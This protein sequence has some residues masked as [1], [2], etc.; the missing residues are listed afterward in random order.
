[1]LLG[2]SRIRGLISLASVVAVENRVTISIPARPIQRISQTGRFIQA[3]LVECG[4][5]LLCVVHR[6]IAVVIDQRGKLIQV[7]HHCQ[8]IRL[9]VWFA[10][11]VPVPEP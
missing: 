5:W 10:Y 4:E 6:R 7:I 1:M 2:G 8:V 9:T 3:A 11:I